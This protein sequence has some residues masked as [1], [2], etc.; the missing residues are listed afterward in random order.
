MWGDAMT[1]KL[2]TSEN[3]RRFPSEIA[4]HYPGLKNLD[5]LPVFVFPRLLVCMDCGFT[6]FAVPEPELRLLGKDVR[7]HGTAPSP[8]LHGGADLAELF[9]GLPSS[10]ADI[11]SSEGA[12]DKSDAT[13]NGFYRH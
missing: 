8:T 7:A 10:G 5:K 11:E 4:V 13:D 9:P 12:A 6:E 3:Q 1:C 2:C